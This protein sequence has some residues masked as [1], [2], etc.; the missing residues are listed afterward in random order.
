MLTRM[1][2]RLMPHP[3]GPKAPAT[4]SRIS[5][6][7]ARSA[8]GPWLLLPALLLLAAGCASGGMDAPRSAFT[9]KAECERTGGQWYA[10]LGAGQGGCVYPGR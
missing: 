8:V 1:T 3:L 4:R 7:L 6:C 9:P 10:R 2:T 5:R